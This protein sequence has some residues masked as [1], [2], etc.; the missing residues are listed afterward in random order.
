MVQSRAIPMEQMK[1]S[2][3]ALFFVGKV[4]VNFDRAEKGNK[5]LLLPA[6]IRSRKR[7]GDRVSR[8][9]S[10]NA[11]P[12]RCWS[13][14]RERKEIRHILIVEINTLCI[15]GVGGAHQTGFRK[16]SPPAARAERK[17]LRGG[18]GKFAR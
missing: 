5:I 7:S 6:L 10:S 3:D 8:L 13:L 17:G 16:T 15:S 12:R 9:R 18:P 11:R 2:I 1:E 4:V 14:G